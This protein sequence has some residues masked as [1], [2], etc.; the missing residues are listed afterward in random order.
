MK[1]RLKELIK[2][3]GRKTQEFDSEGYYEGC[4]YPIYF[5]YP[6]I[7]KLNITPDLCKNGYKFGLEITKKYG[8]QIWINELKPGD[9]IIVRF[10]NTLHPAIYIGDNKIIHVFYDKTLVINNLDLFNQKYFMCFTWKEEVE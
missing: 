5:L 9:V 7:E 1:E 4:L 8:K 10:N 3:V 2:Q 6:N